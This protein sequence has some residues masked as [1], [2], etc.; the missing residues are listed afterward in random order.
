M[1]MPMFMEA[2]LPHPRKEQGLD[3]DAHAHGDRVVVSMDRQGPGQRQGTR[4]KDWAPKRTSKRHR[5]AKRSGACLRTPRFENNP[6]VLGGTRGPSRIGYTGR[7]AC[8]GTDAEKRPEVPQT[9]RSASR[10]VSLGKTISTSKPPPE[11]REARI[12]PPCRSTA[13]L[14]MARPRPTPPLRRSRAA[15]LR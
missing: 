4:N 12:E 5:R 9:R 2:V 6:A 3:G 15:S 1:A 14:A 7:L 8:P 10:R 11:A 13:R